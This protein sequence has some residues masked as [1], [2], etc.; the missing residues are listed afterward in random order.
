MNPRRSAR[1]PALFFPPF[2]LLVL[3]A[4]CAGTRPAP[5]YAWDPK[6]DFA[7]LKSY[8]WSDGPGFRM[9]HGDSIIDGRFIDQHVRGSVDRALG[10]RGFQ[11]ADPASADF[12]VAYRTGDVGVSDE[13][14]IVG[15]D[16]WSGYAVATEYE[17]SRSIRIDIRSKANV[18]L[19]RG[20]ITRLEGEN[21]D[22]VARELDR[23]VGDLLSHFPPAPGAV[24]TT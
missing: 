19:W 18:L 20:Q 13:D 22:A 12:L 14:H 17:K 15:G 10:A 23:E 21:P 8:A 4:G 7:P 11:R 1:R 9:P 5:R 2:V 16:W 24:P 3:A 6:A